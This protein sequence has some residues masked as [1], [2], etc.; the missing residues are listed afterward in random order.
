[1]KRVVVLMLLLSPIASL[2][3][4]LAHEPYAWIMR[5]HPECCGPADCF[6]LSPPPQ[7]VPGGFRLST[8]EFVPEAETKPSR[9]GRWWRCYFGDDTS[10]P[11]RGCLFV[12]PG[13]F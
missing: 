11:R 10:K 6:P 2:H 3:E 8:G 9:D 12:P 1:M 13:G 5:H 7:S 4:A